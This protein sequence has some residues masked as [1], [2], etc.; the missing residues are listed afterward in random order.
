MQQ[1][2]IGTNFRTPLGWVGELPGR[3]NFNIAEGRPKNPKGEPLSTLIVKTLGIIHCIQIPM[4]VGK[5]KYNSRAQHNTNPWFLIML[6]NNSKVEYHN[7]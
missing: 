5:I 4:G 6:F 1:T 7:F 2:S 3:L